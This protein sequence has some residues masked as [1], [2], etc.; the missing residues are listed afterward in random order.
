MAKKTPFPV[1]DWGLVKSHSA[2]SVGPVSLAGS[3]LQDFAALG[4]G[5]WAHVPPTS[6][7]C[8][9][10]EYEWQMGIPFFQP[11]LILGISNPSSQDVTEVTLRTGDGMRF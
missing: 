5:K 6:Q 9:N 1:L 3:I 2:P 8:G 11:S 7:Q 4:N 10:Q